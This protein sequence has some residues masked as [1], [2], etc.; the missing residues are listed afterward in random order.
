MVASNR[1]TDHLDHL[2]VIPDDEHKLLPVAAVY[3]ANGAGKS[4]LVKALSF[5]ER[6]VLVGTEPKQPISRK[7][8]AMDKDSANQPTELSLQFTDGVRVYAYGFRVTDKFVSAEWLSLLRGGKETIVYERLTDNDGKVTIEAGPVLD[9]DSWGDN[10]KALALTKVGVLPNQLFLHVAG[11]NLREEDQG[12]I[13]AGVLKWFRIGLTIIDPDAAF[14]NL[15]RLVALDDTFSS[16]AS[17][18]LKRVE[19]GVDLLKADTVTVD[20]KFLLAFPDDV[21]RNIESLDLGD[22][23]MLVDPSGTRRF[24]EKTSEGKILLRSLRAEHLL[25][26]GSRVELPFSEESDGTQRVTD[27]LPA[28]HWVGDVVSVFVID[29]I[30][31]SLHPL[32]AKGFVRKFLSACSKNGG[33]LIFTTHETAFLDTSLLRRDEIW[34]TDKKLPDGYTRLYSLADFKPRKDLKI[35]KAYLQG[36]FDAIPPIE[37][38]MP[39]WVAAIIDELKPKLP[40]DPEASL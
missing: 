2:R 9:D 26:D 7:A 40:D 32:L 12:P 3:G 37:A 36:R 35:D 25:K 4:N 19:T 5:M 23:A 11:K 16:F 27:L 6:L 22:S 13:L 38:V 14:G 21:R 28:M 39:D 1:P 17:E 30:D 31:R 33:Q 10:S 34:F 8:F 20:E 24:V 15:A 29:E 18:F